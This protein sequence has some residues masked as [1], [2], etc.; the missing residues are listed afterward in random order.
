[1][2][3]VSV[4][5]TAHVAASS[6]VIKGKAVQV[7]INAV[8]QVSSD[9]VSFGA[10]GAV[11]RLVESHAVG[12]DELAD[13]VGI[14]AIVG[15]ANLAS[16]GDWVCSLAVGIKALPTDELEVGLAGSANC[17]KRDAVRRE[18]SALSVSEKE[19]LLARPAGACRDVEAEVVCY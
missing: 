2:I 1:M 17:G 15:E 10:V 6:V 19:A 4:E 9:A 11:Q 5:R 7:L 12:V 13:S 18:R 3:V 8:L 14:D 16:A